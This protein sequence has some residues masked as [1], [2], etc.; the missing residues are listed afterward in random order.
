MTALS[1]AAHR[2]QAD[3]LLIECRAKMRLADEYDA[4]QEQ[5][6]VATHGGARNFNVPKEDV[7]PCAADLGL[8]RKQIHEA[9]QLRDAERDRR[10]PAR[11][12][13]DRESG[14]EGKNGRGQEPSGKFPEGS[15]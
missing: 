15:S 5:G 11:N 4:A 7:E 1:R 3:A 6:E 10:D 9:R 12:A 2:A 8:T 14:G 13:A